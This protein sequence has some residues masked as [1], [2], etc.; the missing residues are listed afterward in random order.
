MA[1]HEGG[2]KNNVK[3]SGN[4]EV[5]GER[6]QLLDDLLLAI[7][8]KEKMRRVKRDDFSELNRRILYVGK[9]IRNTAISHMCSDCKEN[10][11]TTTAGKVQEKLPSEEK[12][13]AYLYERITMEKMKTRRCS[14]AE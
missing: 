12:K 3:A 2:V 8:E 7:D 4:V 5:V 1:G 13:N 10:G 14:F 6:K 11:I 9:N